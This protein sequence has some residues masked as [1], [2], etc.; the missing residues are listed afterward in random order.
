MIQETGIT[1]NF[2]DKLG[3]S[4][5]CKY[6]SEFLWTNTLVYAN[7]SEIIVFNT[8]FTDIDYTPIF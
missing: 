2:E 5:K 4:L 1:P 6:L 7:I 8:R 3:Y